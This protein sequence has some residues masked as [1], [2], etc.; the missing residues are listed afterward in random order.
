MYIIHYN[1]KKKYKESQTFPVFNP[2]NGYIYKN[3]F[4][5]FVNLPWALVQKK[6][7]IF[8]FFFCCA[9]YVN[10]VLVFG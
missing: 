5:C 4:F 3:I 8:P 2:L 6:P 9:G 10:G 1:G 7:L